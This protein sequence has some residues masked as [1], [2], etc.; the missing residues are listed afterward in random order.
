VKNLHSTH[1]R[2]YI[3]SYRKAIFPTQG[4]ILRP[5]GK[6]TTCVKKKKTG[7]ES[8]PPEDEPET[9]IVPYTSL[10]DALKCVL[11]RNCFLQVNATVTNFVNFN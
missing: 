3:I 10:F 6:D 4:I 2:L 7:K 11:A 9:V 8:A 1:T 5:V